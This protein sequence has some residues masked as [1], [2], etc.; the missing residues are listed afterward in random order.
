MADSAE[1]RTPGFVCCCK[2]RKTQPGLALGD[3]TIVQIS[4]PRAGK[5]Q[6]QH[7][8]SNINGESTQHRQSTIDSDGAADRAI[9]RDIYWVSIAG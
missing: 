9:R 1:D 5:Q 7:A 6:P 8:E 2:K 3:H 4:D